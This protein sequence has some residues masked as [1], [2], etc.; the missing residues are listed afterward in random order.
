MQVIDCGDSAVGFSLNSTLGAVNFFDIIDAK[1]AV[2]V[3]ITHAKDPVATTDIGFL[4]KLAEEFESRNVM[5]VIVGNDSVAS[6]RDWIKDIEE[7]QSVRCNFAILSDPDCNVLKQYGCA[8][9]NIIE[10]VVKPTS[11][12]CFIIDL[13]KRIRSSSRNSPS[14]GRNWYEVLRQLDALFM[15]TFHRVVCPAN[16]GQGQDVMLHPTASP[17][18]ASLYRFVEA[19]PW[20]RIATCPEQTTGQS[21]GST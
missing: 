14:I 9:T 19:K 5:V 7:L 21:G 6:L 2:L 10:K 18:E 4:A 16:W 15:T 13:D 20:F 11:L 1:W 8:K 12:G 3:T 17:E